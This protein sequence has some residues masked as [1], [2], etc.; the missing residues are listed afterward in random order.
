MHAIVC[1][2]DRDGMTFNHRRVSRD[3]VLCEDIVRM[4]GTQTLHLSCYS[5]P[6]FDAF[7]SLTLSASEN[8]FDRAGKGEYCFFE[9]EAPGR[10]EKHIETLI[11][12][13]WNRRYPSDMKFD[14]DVGLGVWKLLSREDFPGSSHE[15]ITKEIYVK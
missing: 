1:V 9:R 5:V 3:R 12:Y 11:L 8:Y 15:K 7:S 10:W 14:I 6:L 13:R 2:D 4:V